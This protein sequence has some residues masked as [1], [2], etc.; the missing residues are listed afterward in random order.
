[1]ITKFGESA[2]VVLVNGVVSGTWS[3]TREH[4]ID[5][6]VVRM[7]EGSKIDGL[8]DRLEKAASDAGKFYKGAEIEVSI[9]GL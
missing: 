9:K 1:M 4:T 7:F 3:F 6:C 2:S 5:V 8:K